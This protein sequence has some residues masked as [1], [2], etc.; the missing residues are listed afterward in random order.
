MKTKA[1]RLYGAD[2]IRL[3][4]FE[5]PEITDDEIL[6]KVVSDSLCM[7]TYKEVKQGARHIRVPDDIKENPVII[8]HE[9]SGDIIKVGKHWQDTYHAG[10][11]FALLPGI[12][13]QMEAPGYSY[14]H[15]GGDCTYC[16]VPE[17]V[18]RKECFFEIEMD[19]YYEVSVVE[20]LY[21]V[22]GGYHA[23]LHT[24]SGTHQPRYST[25]KDGNL[26][27]L[28]GCGP[29]G[30]MA[31]GYALAKENGPKRVVVT[32]IDDVKLKRTQ[33]LISEEDARKKGIE[34][35]YIN[36]GK[37]DN[38]VEE[39]MGLTKGEGYHDVFV[40]TPIKPVAETGNAVLAF[41]GCMN[42]FAG[43]ADKN[44]S[45]VMNLY[46]CHYRNTKIIGSSG[47]LRE[48]FLESLEL[49]RDKKV[50]PATMITHIGGLDSVVEATCALP[51][52]PGAKK[53]IYTQ[54]SMPL[55]AIE[56][57][58]ELGEKNPLFKELHACCERHDG[59]WNP[60]AEK[61]L[62]SAEMKQGA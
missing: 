52:I 59:L 16:I 12:P 50:N 27:I 60:E 36:T 40:Y 53:L 22:I 28:G 9:F 20:P 31:I 44:F 7:S 19:S 10:K 48:D 17:D 58:E 8:G 30:I 24:V 51:S 42:L 56:E 55:T 41:D 6:V 61:I 57:F 38:E 33:K 34:L 15:L 43:P 37:V 49:I 18:I 47:G 45:A 26:L 13:D 35:H 11:R 46:D 32:D 2:D 29:M 1:V 21:C 14:Q 4:E 39:L 3:E 5:L 62:L 25:K 54:I 23:N